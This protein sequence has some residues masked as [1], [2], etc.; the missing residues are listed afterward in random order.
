M[1]LLAIEPNQWL[2]DGQVQMP[3]GKKAAHFLDLF[4]DL[5]LVLAMSTISV[6]FR[7][8]LEHVHGIS[9]VPVLDVFAFL[10]PIW[11]HSMALNAFSNRFGKV[12]SL[13]TVSFYFLNV[14]CMFF[15]SPTP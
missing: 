4:Y 12:E 2:E 6:D 14:I 5:L 7:T 3:K 15:F 13:F 9:L 1:Q 8:K 10:A 11:L